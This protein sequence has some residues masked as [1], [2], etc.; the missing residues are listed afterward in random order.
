MAAKTGAG[1]YSAIYT[2]K[3]GSR[4]EGTRTYNLAALVSWVHNTLGAHESLI[5]AEIRE[6]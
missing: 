6:A 4:V 1:A 3:D 2:R 5:G